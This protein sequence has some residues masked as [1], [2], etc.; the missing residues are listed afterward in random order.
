MAVPTWTM[1]AQRRVVP[2]ALPRNV[3]V[4]HALLSSR[5]QRKLAAAPRHRDTRLAA[6][7]QITV[8][9][10][11]GGPDLEAGVEAAENASIIKVA[12]KKP[13]GLT[14]EVEHVTQEPEGGRGLLCHRCCSICA[15]AVDHIGVRLLVVDGRIC[16]MHGRQD[17]AT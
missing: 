13:L 17:G 9:N 7:S 10:L 6:A 3:R 14:L 5:A 15:L 11:D 8:P 1:H 2:A 16:R 4:Q 12:L